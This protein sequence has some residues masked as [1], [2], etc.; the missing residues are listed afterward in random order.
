MEDLQGGQTGDARRDEHVEREG[1]RDTHAASLS[2]GYPMTRYAG[3]RAYSKKDHAG[4]AGMRRRSMVR[5][6]SSA[7]T[8]PSGQSRAMRAVGQPSSSDARWVLSEM[9]AASQP[10]SDPPSR[11][12][13]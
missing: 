4:R 9:A 3:C 10:P 7:F 13:R 2:G 1:P 11:N 12:W 6:Y 8:V 5:S